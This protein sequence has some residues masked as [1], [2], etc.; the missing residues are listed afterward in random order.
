MFITLVLE[1][2]ARVLVMQKRV[3]IAALNTVNVRRNG[4]GMR[5]DGGVAWFKIYVLL[6]PSI[7]GPDVLGEWP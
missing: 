3:K 5:I 7:I 6:T 1:Y 4:F 2:S